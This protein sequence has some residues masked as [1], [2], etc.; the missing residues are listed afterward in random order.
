MCPFGAFL[1]GLIMYGYKRIRIDGIACLTHRHLMEEHIGRK[2]T[3]KEVVHHI[4]GDKANNILSNLKLMSVGAHVSLHNHLR[5]SRDGFCRRS[6]KRTRMTK[7]KLYLIISLINKRR[8]EKH[9]AEA[10]NVSCKFIRNI[11]RKA[12]WVFK[13]YSI[14]PNIVTWT[15]KA[16]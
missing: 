13:Y 9:I 10:F 11:K 5:Y 8:R 14:D 16:N 12:S 7:M 1:V 15:K 6:E 3:S 4:D 2:L